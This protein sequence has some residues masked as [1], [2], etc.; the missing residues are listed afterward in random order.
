MAAI[1]RDIL[2]LP[3]VGASDNFF[4]LGG[5]SLLA[6][7]LHR[8]LRTEMAPTLS[9]TDVFRFPRSPACARISTA[10]PQR[11]RRWT[12]YRTVRSGASRHWAGGN[13]RSRV[14]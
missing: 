2:R 4:D 12:G 11:T 14:S 7:Q 9:I 6:V 3:R 10:S 5:H 13:R 1:W 8:R